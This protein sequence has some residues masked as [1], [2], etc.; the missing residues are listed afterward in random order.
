MSDLYAESRERFQRE[1]GEHLMTVLREDGLYRHLR[2]RRPGTSMYGFDI[3]TWPGYLAI[4]GDIGSYTFSRVSDMLRF[5]AS[6][7]DINPHY[8]EEKIVSN[9]RHGG[10][11]EYSQS[12]FERQVKQYV[13]DKIEWDD[14]D[15]E[16]AAD[17]WTLV[18]EDVLS[19]GDHVE[20][21][22]E[23]LTNFEYKGFEFV[24]SWEWDLTDYTWHYLMCCQ[25]IR[26]ASRLFLGGDGVLAMQAL[27]RRHMYEAV[28]HLRERVAKSYEALGVPQ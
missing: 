24:D 6:G 25:A 19:A 1:C 23:V 18:N 4:T 12:L 21:A 14:L 17:L 27:G 3:I 11:K 20:T 10:A 16:A 9:D 15:A 26:Y 7:P 13:A 28:A 5:F 22:R 8:W 2:F